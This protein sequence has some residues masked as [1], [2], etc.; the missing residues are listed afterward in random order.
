MHSRADHMVISAISCTS[1][2]G[3]MPLAP[4]HSCAA[5][6]ETALPA[7]PPGPAALLRLTLLMPT[8][9]GS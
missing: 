1:H 4:A 7:G 5:P 3:G 6:L 2:A 9:P 8:L